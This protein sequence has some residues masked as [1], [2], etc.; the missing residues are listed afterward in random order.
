MRYE[1]MIGLR[2]L[3]A[4]R[5]Q[6]FVSVI[7]FI[8]V[9]G[10]TVGVAALIIVLSFML[11]V[12]D[13]MRDKILGFNA[14]IVV[15]RSSGIANPEEI[16]EKLD[17]VPGVTGSSPFIESQV[18][19]R[20]PHGQEGALIRG[21]DLA[22]APRVMNLDEHV[23]KGSMSELE[24]ADGDSSF[25]EPLPVI[26]LGTELAGQV[27]AYHGS[28]VSVII[29]EGKLTPYGF[30]PKAKRFRVGCIYEFGF[31]EIDA[32]VALVSLATA[33]KVFD[34]GDKVDAIEVK[35]D[36][37]YNVSATRK[38]VEQAIQYPYIVRTWID[39]QQQL[40]AALK[41]EQILSGLVLS[42]IMLVASFNII[43]M[44]LMLVMEKYRDIAVLKS[45]G[46]TDGGIMMIFMTQGTAIG[47]FG[48]IAGV[49]L[50]LFVCW[51]QI[52]FGLLKMPADVYQFGTV[53]V[54]ISGFVIAGV[55][56]GA[57]L[58]SFV[59]TIYPSWQASKIKPAE[60]LRYE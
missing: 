29:P 12:Q 32:N 24:P 28:E 45:M 44:L 23:I 14:H 47:L 13:Y 4:K 54:K 37:V 26:A 36:N 50:G 52:E 2:Y 40:F 7:T 5:K 43:G 38:R 18:L 31:Y 34:R 20:G 1:I 51:L 60:S 57:M 8:S 59:T 46:A 27:G 48:A 16:M 22:T 30:A 19:V 56:L 9:A 10:V 35:T 17:A 21:I 58:L 11:G 6:T 25:L 39:Q 42:L 15:T 55:S 41:M 3:R 53:P 33:G 49:L